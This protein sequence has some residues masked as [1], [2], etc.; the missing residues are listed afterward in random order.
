MGGPLHLLCFFLIRNTWA[1]YP[2]RIH[3]FFSI[4]SERKILKKKKDT[5]NIFLSV[6][7]HFKKKTFHVK[8][9]PRKH[10]CKYLV[11]VEIFKRFVYRDICIEKCNSDKISMVMLPL[12]NIQY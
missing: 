6:E 1:I 8:I 11:P 12:S 3:L 9:L 4:F 10:F 2:Y 5:F 7:N